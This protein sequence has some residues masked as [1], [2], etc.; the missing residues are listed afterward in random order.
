ME[1]GWAKE[2]SVEDTDDDEETDEEEDEETY[3]EG[4]SDAV[5]EYD[6]D[7]DD[8][9]DNTLDAKTQ[10]DS[11]RVLD[12][13]IDRKYKAFMDD[14]SELDSEGESLVTD[15]DDES[16]YTMEDNN[17]PFVDP[18]ECSEK[19]ESTPRESEET[20]APLSTEQHEERPGWRLFGLLS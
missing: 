11:R 2:D 8:D 6:D 12:D 16:A 18:I 9:D 1:E 5:T 15:D 13:A 20:D 7:E 14:I 10:K 4:E 3:S 17:V 19:V